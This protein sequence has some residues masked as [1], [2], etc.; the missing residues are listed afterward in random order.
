MRYELGKI[1]YENNCRKL[2]RKR[3]S[4]NMQGSTKFCEFLGIGRN[5]VEELA[6]KKIERRVLFRELTSYVYDGEFF[7]FNHGRI[8]GVFRTR[9]HRTTLAASR[10]FVPCIFGTPRANRVA[11]V[12][13][14]C[15]PLAGGPVPF[16]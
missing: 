8:K 3:A 4:G 7:A 2:V 15:A 16:R 9:I 5:V 12:R 6:V 10:E 14:S 13:L 11:R 1:A